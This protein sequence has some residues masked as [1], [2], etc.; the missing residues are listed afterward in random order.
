MKMNVETVDNAVQKNPFD[1]YMGFRV[2]KADE[3]STILVFQNEGTS[4]DNP[5][6]TMYGGVLYSMA[7]STMETACA[8]CG[9]AV[10]TLDLSMNYLRPAFSDTTI[11]AEAKVIHNGH[12]TMVALCDFYDNKD[13][14]LAH[15]KGTFFVTGPY[16]FGDGDDNE[17]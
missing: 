3:Q 5:N 13:R 7:D 10:L 8:V 16:R 6:G 15:G 2:L 12:T 11:R 14:Y 17:Y 9:K 4:W 1:N